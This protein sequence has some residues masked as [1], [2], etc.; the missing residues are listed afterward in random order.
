MGILDSLNG[1]Q[2]R[3][4]LQL[5]ADQYKAI[6]DQLLTEQNP[7]MRPLLETQQKQIAAQIRELEAAL[8]VEVNSIG[9]PLPRKTCGL[10][11][12]PTVPI[13]VGRDVLVAKL[14]KLLQVGSLPRV[15]SIIGQGGVGKSSLTTKLL[16]H[17]GVDIAS[18]R[19]LPSCNFDRIVILSARGGLSFESA[20][21]DLWVG[22]APDGMDVESMIAGIV[23][24]LADV[25]AL[26]VLDN[27][28]DLLYLGGEAQAGQARDADWSLLLNAFAN[29]SH[30]SK[31]LVTSQ[32]VLLD[33]ADPRYGLEADPEIVETVLLDGLSITDGVAVLQRRRLD[34]PMD[35]LEWVANRVGGNPLLL[36]QLAALGRK[37]PGYLRKHPDIVTKN[38][39]KVLAAQL[40]RQSEA[41][42]L[43]LRRMGLIRRNTDLQG[44]TFLSLYQDAWEADGR[45]VQRAER[46][47]RLEFEPEALE[48]TGELVAALLAS[49]LIKEQYDHDSGEMRYSLHPSVADF[50]RSQLEQESAALLQRVAEFYASGV[51]ER[52]SEFLQEIQ[53]VADVV[54][55]MLNLDEEREKD[56]IGMTLLRVMVQAGQSDRL[57][58][59]LQQSPVFTEQDNQAQAI[60]AMAQINYQLG[61]W[62]EA[63]NLARQALQIVEAK[64]D[65]AGLAMVWGQLGSIERN[66]GNW[67]EAERLYRQSLELRTELGDRSGMASSWG[68]LGDI[69]R[70]RGNWDEAERLFRQSLELQTELG[71]RSG[72]ATSW[73]VLGDI[74]RNRGNWDEAERLY[75]QCLEIETELG[76]RSGM[77]SC[78]G[79][80]GD[81]ER[82]R[83]NWDEAEQLFKQ[84]LEMGQELGDTLGTAGAVAYLGENELSRGDLEKAEQFL[85]DA[86]QTMEKLGSTDLIARLNFDLA[87]LWQRRNN[88]DRAQHH[89]TIA[90][91]LYTQLGAAKDLERIETE[92]NPQ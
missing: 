8:P 61:N 38:I 72:M 64:G 62:N 43:L 76:D 92:F 45:I 36:T 69:E 15:I 28:E 7:V 87:Q 74:E 78:W 67:D 9:E 19:L 14:V 41:A 5:L 85:S 51:N 77:A 20:M 90:R 82:K 26:V 80:L 24:G 12:L 16:E 75:R 40:A 18:D 59:F 17:I 48:A 10:S 71:D 70:K 66:R 65:R 60:L 3:Q 2:D 29:R 11:Q 23:R 91:D 46:N 44:L 33:F 47:Q 21:A 30:R 73:G 79:V 58:Q 27:A 32:Q 57:T 63:E 35:D 56:E 50:A 81:I 68:V 6:G 39:S 22:C 88:P 83:G 42:R 54:N 37:R 1:G 86:L 49:D 52:T 31:L 34:D 89:Y 25:P 4:R 53:R 55:L 13:W 84:K